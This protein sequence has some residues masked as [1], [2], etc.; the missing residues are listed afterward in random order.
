MLFT[1]EKGKEF[2]TKDLGFISPFD[3]FEEK[4]QPSDPLA[5]EVV[6][7]M[8]DKDLYNIDWNFTSFPSQAFKDFFGQ[9]LGQYASGEMKWDEVKDSFVKTWK[10]EKAAAK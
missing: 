7:Y 3:T 8:S 1:S 9:A 4:D 2:V 5:K 6:K 10:D